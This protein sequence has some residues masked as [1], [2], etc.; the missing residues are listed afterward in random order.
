MWMLPLSL[1]LGVTQIFEY[2]LG[3]ECSTCKFKYLA[4]KEMNEKLP[5]A[6]GGVGQYLSNH[7]CT[8]N[9]ADVLCSTL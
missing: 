8:V 2:Y 7:R 1:S 5:A 9:C 6:L 4:S 3:A